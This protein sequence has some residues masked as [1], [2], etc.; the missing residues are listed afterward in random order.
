MLHHKSAKPVTS[1]SGRDRRGFST[2]VKTDR[3]RS[4]ILQRV[5]SRA[6]NMHSRVRLIR[7]KWTRINSNNLLGPTKLLLAGKAL[8]FETDGIKRDWAAVRNIDALR[9]PFFDLT[10][11][12][13]R[14]IGA[15]TRA[16]APM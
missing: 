15:I 9:D 3:P 5:I 11:R 7:S 4:S 13:S 2:S 8:L 16:L 14:F 12:A 6:T 1:S 10:I